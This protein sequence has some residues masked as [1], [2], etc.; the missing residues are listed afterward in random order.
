MSAEGS[1]LESL[2]GKRYPAF[3]VKNKETGLYSVL[4]GQFA[5]ASPCGETFEEA[6]ADA[7]YLLAHGLQT[8]LENGEV[9]P[10]PVGLEEAKHWKQY[11]FDEVHY[12]M[13]DGDWVEVELK[14][15]LYN[16]EDWAGEWM[17]IDAA[18]AEEDEDEE[19]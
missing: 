3:A 11:L 9:L 2:R 6:M 18:I 5:F 12:T 15:E 8:M 1:S 14:P 19:D 16:A 7:E 4:Y 10:G 13:D 17:P